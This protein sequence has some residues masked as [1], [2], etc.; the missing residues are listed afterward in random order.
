MDDPSL[1]QGRVR[2]A[3]HV[4]GQWAAYVF[5]PVRLDPR[6]RIARVL[7]EVFERAREFVGIL[8]PIA[9]YPNS[10]DGDD[11]GAREH[12]LHISLS[13]PV[14]LR[15]HQREDLKRAVKTI[16]KSHSP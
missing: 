10:E 2:T 6:D 15:S 9:I 4:D 5:L 12:E 3:P 16:A 14:Y 1:H 11:D 7:T 13:R 8:H